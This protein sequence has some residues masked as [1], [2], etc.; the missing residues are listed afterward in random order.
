MLEAEHMQREPITV[1]P[2]R[3]PDDRGF[4]YILSGQTR[5]HAA[6]LAGWAELKAQLNTVIDPDDHVG[7]FCCIY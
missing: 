2:G 7:F 3:R 1:V 5:Y 4:F 6:N